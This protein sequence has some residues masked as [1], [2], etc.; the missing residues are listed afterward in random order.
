MSYQTQFIEL[1]ISFRWQ[2]GL[3]SK[4]IHYSI[5]DLR[6]FIHLSHKSSNPA[7]YI[8]DKKHSYIINK[9]VKML[10]TISINDH[11]NKFIVVDEY[12]NFLHQKENNGKFK[13]AIEILHDN[14]GNYKNLAILHANILKEM[15]VNVLIISSKDK[16]LWTVAI[17][18]GKGDVYYKGK[19]YKS[20]KLPYSGFYYEDG[21]TKKQYPLQIAAKDVNVYPLYEIK[22]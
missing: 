22:Y 4:D 10:M 8:T 21:H 7:D 19:W 15:G 14:Q 16:K 20:K 18:S 13:Y 6:Y 2:G 5:R 17:E 1:T 12:I 9:V 3:I 11:I